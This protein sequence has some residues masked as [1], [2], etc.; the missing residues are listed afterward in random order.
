MTST[1]KAENKGAESSVEGTGS[2][3]IYQTKLQFQIKQGN[4]WCINPCFG[5]MSRKGG[6][7]KK[8]WEGRKAGRKEEGR[9]RCEE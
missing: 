9:I 7:R 8:G 3:K 5:K 4:T 1:K 6:R 2:G